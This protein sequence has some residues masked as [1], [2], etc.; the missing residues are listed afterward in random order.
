MR[1][2]RPGT[3][4]RKDM[5]AGLRRFS[6][7]EAIERVDQID[8]E[9]LQAAGKTLLLLDVDHT[10]LPW[11]SEE[12]PGAV[13]EWVERAKA[14][15]FR[16]CILSNTNN[17]ARLEGLCRSLGVEFVRAKN[18]PSRQMFRLALA[19]FGVPPE[20]AV[21]IGDQLFTD[22]LGAN[23]SGIDAI[24]VRPMAGR[25]F[26]ATTLIS[27]N[28]ERVMAVLLYRYFEHPGE[29]AVEAGEQGL[30]SQ[31]T[32]NQFGRFVAVGV[33][34]SLIDVGL[35]F[36]LMFG[37]QVDGQPLAVALGSHLVTTYPDLFAFAKGRVSDA[38]IP[39]LKVPVT[40]VAILN[41][42]YWNRRWTFEV[43]DA[44]TRSRQMRRY[45]VVA[46]TAM[47]VNAAVTTMFNT[48]IPGHPKLSLGIASVI[49]IVVAGVYNF[50]LQ[51]H[52]TFRQ[53][54]Q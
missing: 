43:K 45:F 46:L 25:E 49:A 12:I 23:R 35:L 15:G 27:R 10:L 38:A 48:V 37:Y 54:S 40:L 26:F 28:L 31:R 19:K 13:R 33:S 5:P 8:L 16:L 32:V 52:W 39:I 14:L 36:L 53:E 1:H 22:V 3:F 44:V 41:G 21:M 4:V 18:K 9:A 17:V 34:S 7:T 29:R 50:L 20:E 24:W 47:V 30:Y 6:P 2:V 42:F 11:R 51:R